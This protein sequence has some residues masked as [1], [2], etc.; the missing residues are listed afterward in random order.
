MRK[1]K[2]MK[3]QYMT[4]DPFST[5]KIIFHFYFPMSGKYTH[6]GSNVS[7]DQV[8]VA[9]GNQNVLLVEATKRIIDI[10]SFDDLL[11][12]GSNKDILKFL[13]TENL[14][15]SKLN[16]RFESMLY[17]LKD[18][19]FFSAVI[20]ILRER[21]I[22]NAKVWQFAFF[23]QEDDELMRECLL[24]NKGNASFINIGTHFKSSLLEIN[25]AN[26][27]TG[28]TMCL[29]YF[30]MVNTRAHRIG[31]DGTHAILN[32]TFSE[33]YN[34]FLSTLAQK[35]ALTMEDKMTFV[36][37]LQLQDR[38]E[39]AITLFK[40]LKAPEAN[41]MLKVQHDYLLAYFDFFTDAKDGYLVARRIVQQYDNYPI[42]K[43]RMM[44]LAIMDQ[45]NEFDGEFDQ[46]EA[47]KIDVDEL[48]ASSQQ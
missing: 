45:L 43:W 44:F 27:K 17:L 32:K 42:T 16:F 15:S 40:T 41:S 34:Q 2:Y 23:H 10:Q 9:K 29:E 28:Y 1:T 31:Q 3:S 20:K 33:T 4:L 24:L 7:I 47:D 14:N 13:Q 30:P 25:D 22:Y 39:E 36:Y 35:G 26:A 21:S 19:E 46:A 6:F 8:V 11:A 37:Y 5:K 12:A 48:T 38:I 18:K